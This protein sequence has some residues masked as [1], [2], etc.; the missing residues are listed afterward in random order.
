MNMRTLNL[1]DSAHTIGI[2]LNIYLHHDMRYIM[3][4]L[5]GGDALFFHTGMMGIVVMDSRAF[6]FMMLRLDAVL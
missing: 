1:C 2:T 4:L 5:F 3:C 6:C